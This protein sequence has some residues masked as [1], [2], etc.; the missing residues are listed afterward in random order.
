MIIEYHRP[1]K[2]EEALELIARKDPR[3]VPMGGGTVLATPKS[4]D[5]AV[6]DLQLLG[7]NK[8]SQTAKLF[9]VGA[10][11]TLQDLLQLDQINPE[12]AKTIELESTRTLRQSASV[13]GALVSADGRSPLAIAALAMDAQFVVEPEK[14]NLSFGEILPLRKNA[15]KERII[16]AVH[17]PRNVFLTYEY[18]ARTPADLPIVALALAKWPSGRTRLVAGGFGAQP[19]LALDGKDDSGLADALSNALHGSTDKWAEEEYRQE[20]GK[21]LLTRAIA[22]IKEAG[23]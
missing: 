7:L 4:E 18:V 23:K 21:A 11:A 2:V 1:E 14:E 15:L 6:V 20:A 9:K 13:A 10:T 16:V 22:N 12:L 19:A 8:I 5:L 17:F 3:T